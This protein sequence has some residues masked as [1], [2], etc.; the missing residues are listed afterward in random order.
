MGKTLESIFISARSFAGASKRVE[1][2]AA[3]TLVELKF[4][5]VAAVWGRKTDQMSGC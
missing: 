4:H 1:T 5:G 2:G 3:I